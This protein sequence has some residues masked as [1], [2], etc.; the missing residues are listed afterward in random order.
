MASSVIKRALDGKFRTI[1]SG[2]MKDIKESGIYYV[3]ASVT[4]R[5]SGVGGFYFCSAYSASVYGGLFFSP[6]E[7]TFYLFYTSDGTNF[8]SKQLSDKI[9]ET[10]TITGTTT[11]T[12]ALDVPY[13]YRAYTFISATMVSQNGY[14][15]RRD[16]SYFMVKDSA[17]QPIAN[18]EVTL[19]AVFMR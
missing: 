13:D 16:A 17:L 8:S 10:Y 2:S 11:S 9:F 4:D 6:Y 12:G 19:T 5:P 7:A 15:F 18:T 14:V 3:T 1:T